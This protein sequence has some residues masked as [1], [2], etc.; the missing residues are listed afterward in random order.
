MSGCAYAVW[1]IKCFK[2]MR[3]MVITRD[4]KNTTEASFCEIGVLKDVG[5]V[6]AMIGDLGE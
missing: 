5:E 3:D 1:M 4:N 6:V 2:C